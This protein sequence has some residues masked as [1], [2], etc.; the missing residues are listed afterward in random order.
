M[1][2]IRVY[3]DEEIR[4]LISNSNVESIKNKCQIVYKNEFK[5]WAVKEKLNH[6]EKTAREIFAAGGF[7]MTILD[8]MTPQRRL[9]SWVKKYKMYGENYFISDKYS[10]KA[11]SKNDINQVIDKAE[12]KIFDDP[13]FIA[14]VVEKQNDGSL[15]SRIIRK[16][17]EKTNN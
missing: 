14:F 7:D 5:L 15:K 6:V 3:N 9:C 13:T 1:K 8:E 16:E 11:K 4:K 2:K 17:N 12:N 10:Y